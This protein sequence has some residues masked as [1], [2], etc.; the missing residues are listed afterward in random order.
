[1]SKLCLEALSF[2]FQFQWDKS[3]LNTRHT[4][5][6]RPPQISKIQSFSTI[7]NG[8]SEALHLSSLP[9]S[10][11][12][13][14]NTPLKTI[15][16]KVPVVIPLMRISWPEFPEAYSEPYQISKIELFLV[17]IVNCWQPRKKLNLRYLVGFWISPEIVRLGIVLINFL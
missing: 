14:G 12:H 1:M 5:A 17:K 15:S 3:L 6:W 4:E 10:W 13:V 9:G 16:G 2:W 7:G 11:L 8:C